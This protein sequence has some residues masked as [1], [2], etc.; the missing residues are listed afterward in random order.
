MALGTNQNSFFARSGEQRLRV[1]DKLS[2][3]PLAGPVR[4]A[5]WC[6]LQEA[7]ADPHLLPSSGWGWP[8]CADSKQLIS[9]LSPSLALPL[10]LWIPETHQLPTHMR[11]IRRMDITFCAHSRAAHLHPST[12]GRQGREVNWSS[13]TGSYA[14]VGI[15]WL[16]SQMHRLLALQSPVT[17]PGH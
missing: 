1:D 14:R 17:K 8:L 6:P 9:D 12:D 2:Q 10:S 3:Q 5:G 16:V 11:P 15:K 7:T 4:L 13:S